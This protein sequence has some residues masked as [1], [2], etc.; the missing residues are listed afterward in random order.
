MNL[1]A[2][3]DVVSS[4]GCE[5]L[6]KKLPYLKR[7]Y[8]IDFCIANGE[9]SAVGNG[10]LPTS[11][12]FLFQSGIDI[13]TTGNH[14]FKR[15]EIYNYL[16]ENP[17]IIRPGNMH[18]TC[19]GK[20]ITVADM[21]RYQI[22]VINIIGTAYFNSNYSNPFDYLDCS[23]R[24]TYGIPI[25]IVDFHAEATGEKKALGYYADGRVSA[26]FGTHTHVQTSDASILPHGT[27]YITDLGMC[28]A[29]NSV[30]GIKPEN[31]INTLKTGL[32]NRFTAEEGNMILE[33]CIFQID[34]NTGKTLSVNPLKIR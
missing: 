15:K 11:A 23:L 1:L 6:R 28:A 4:G 12:D 27:G 8:N 34:E 26:L 16:D 13:I 20:G 9:N 33:G 18:V 7:E 24:E 5:F 29:E 19:P 32:L 10:I 3:G 22:A 30:L 21:G 17:Y 2:I 14:V 31:V 25:R